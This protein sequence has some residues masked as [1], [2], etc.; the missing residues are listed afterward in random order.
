MQPS[1]AKATADRQAAAV[2]GLRREFRP[3]A[4]LFLAES[5]SWEMSLLVFNR[6]GFS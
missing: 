4:R 5:L 2:Q 6:Q 1:F 3:N